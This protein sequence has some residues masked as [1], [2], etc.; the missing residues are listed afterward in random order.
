[1]EK[2]GQ[3]HIDD[4]KLNDNSDFD[5]DLKFGQEYEQKLET[6]LQTPNLSAN[7]RKMVNDQL[8]KVKNKRIFGAGLDVME[9]EP[10]ERNNELMKFE[11]VIL[12]PHSLCWTEECF[13]A[14][15]SEAISKCKYG[16]NFIPFSCFP[17]IVINKNASS[18]YVQNSWIPTF[19]TN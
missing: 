16:Y 7:Q 13:D 17:K 2:I 6:S 4:L 3:T 11:N 10:I 5:L 9:F 19:K 8:N 18:T 14:I 1:M 12:T 15:A